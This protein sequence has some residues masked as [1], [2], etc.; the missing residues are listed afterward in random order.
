MAGDERL[1]E[2]LPG[3]AFGAV[4]G[5][6]GGGIPACSIRRV[7]VN[8]VL[9]QQDAQCRRHFV[10]AVILGARNKERSAG[11]DTSAQAAVQEHRAAELMHAL[12]CTSL[13]ADFAV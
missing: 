7:G 11:R 8:P 9:A 1:N 13:A 3:A 4:H 2:G 10:P 6:S 5:G 12:R